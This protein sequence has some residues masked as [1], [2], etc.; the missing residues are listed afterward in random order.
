MYGERTAVE[1][2]GGNDTLIGSG[3]DDDLRGSDGDDILFG[4]FD[5][6]HLVGGTGVNQLDGGAGADVCLNPSAGTACEL[7]M[8]ARALVSPRRR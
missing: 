1:R 8:R 7:A 3:D 6:D 5:D 2:R 4:D